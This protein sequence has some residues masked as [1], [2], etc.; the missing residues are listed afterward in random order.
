MSAVHDLAL[1]PV[2]YEPSCR[3]EELF[4][5]PSYTL[6]NTER[7]S[8]GWESVFHLISI[9]IYFTPAYR[10]ISTLL[11]LVN[12]LIHCCFMDF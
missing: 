5:L 3:C 2:R 4:P 1:L 11:P 12:I 10:Y 8:E 6:N 9:L 7:A